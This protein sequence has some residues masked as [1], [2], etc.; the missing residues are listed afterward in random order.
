[1]FILF[2][3]PLGEGEGFSEGDELLGFRFPSALRQVKK[4]IR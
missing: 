1:M 2:P 4:S 3:L